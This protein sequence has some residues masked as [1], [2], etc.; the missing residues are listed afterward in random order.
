MVAMIRWINHSKRGLTLVELMLVASLLGFFTLIVGQ[1]IVPLLQRP[2]FEREA[3]ANYGQ[4][5]LLRTMLYNDLAKVESVNI[6]IY[7]SSCALN[8]N[9]MKNQ[10][11]QTKTIRYT[12]DPYTGRLERNDGTNTIVIMN[13]SPFSK[14]QVQNVGPK[15]YRLHLY[16]P[17]S[18]PQEDI[19]VLFRAN[20]VTGSC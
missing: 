14:W 4:Y 13:N 8:I 3:M 19:N 6:Y 7:A 15:L 12:L 1:A 18:L 5:R 2:E 11:N 17:S 20:S 10:Q 16:P 9:T